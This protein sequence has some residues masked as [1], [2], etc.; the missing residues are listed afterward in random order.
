MHL[1]HADKVW[2]QIQWWERWGL[3]FR[4]LWCLEEGRSQRITVNVLVKSQCCGST[5]LGENFLEEAAGGELEGKSRP[6]HCEC[7]EG[8]RDGPLGAE[9][10]R[11]VTARIS[12]VVSP[13]LGLEKKEGVAYRK[14]SAG[15]GKDRKLPAEDISC[16]GLE[17]SRKVARSLL[18]VVH[19]SGCFQALRQHCGN[20]PCPQVRQNLVCRVRL[21]WVSL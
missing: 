19:F 4:D 18:D 20:F 21:W 1:L 14:H 6:L 5:W 15:A 17:E 7:D 12:M 11:I 2:K 13:E 8:W 9:D 10:G 3:N 16:V